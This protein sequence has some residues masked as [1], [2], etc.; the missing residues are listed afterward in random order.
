[1]KAAGDLSTSFGIS[2]SA[3]LPSAPLRAGGIN[4]TGKLAG[5]WVNLPQVANQREGFVL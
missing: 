3:S 1:M 2:P 4:R 5:I